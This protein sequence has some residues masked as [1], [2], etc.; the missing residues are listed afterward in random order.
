MINAGQTPEK[1]LPDPI[2]P[3]PCFI[4]HIISERPKDIRPILIRHVINYVEFFWSTCLCKNRFNR[5]GQQCR[6]VENWYN[7]GNSLHHDNLK[8]FGLKET[9]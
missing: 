8:L 6:P 1:I 5:P 7:H 2:T 3:F 4:R 9:R